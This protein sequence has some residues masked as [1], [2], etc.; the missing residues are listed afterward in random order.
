[1]KRRLSL[2]LFLLGGMMWAH[3]MGNFS[4]SHFS[5]LE[6]AGE[7]ARIRYVIDLAEIP[8]FQLLQQ[9]KADAATATEVLDRKA[10]EQARQW[11]RNLKITVDGRPVQASVEK[12]AAVLDH[13]A[14]NMPILRVIADLAVD[15]APGKLVYEDTNFPDRAGWKEVVVAG[16][17]IDSAWPKG[18]DRSK[19]LTAYPQ[20]PLAA[21][22]QDLKAEV[23]WHGVAPIVTEAPPAPVAVSAQPGQTGAGMVVKGDF[24]SRLLHQGDVGVGMTIL[25]MLVAFGLGAIHALSPGHGK[26]IVAAYLVGARGTAKHAAFLGA[27]VT[28]THTISVF[29]LGFIT[30]FLSRYVL[31]EKIYPVLGAVSGLSIVWIGTSL[32]FKRMRAA[33]KA[34][35]FHRAH[36]HVPEGDVTLGSLMALGASGG[37]V[38]CPSALVLLLSS[39]ALGRIGLGLTL[40][41]AF[42]MGLAVVLMAIGM[43]VLF[44][45]HLLPDDQKRADNLAFRY[46]PVAS[47]AIITCAGLLMTGVALGVTL[48]L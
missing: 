6:V 25:G 4:V 28:F 14:G 27:M 21:P 22:P 17:Q 38:P 37:L 30:L 24:L 32:F 7:G 5:R 47:A 3:P 10:F 12:A 45:K 23:V 34:P 43:V 18:V 19:E 16:P 42:S 29:F 13:G 40:L 46:L 48:P 11:A 8:T 36:S 44:A 2:P 39:V 26:T 31:P 1:M 20:D 33:S 15:C 41:V 9:W 35:R